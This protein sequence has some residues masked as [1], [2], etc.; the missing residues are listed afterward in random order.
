MARGANLNHSL[1][2]VLLVQRGLTVILSGHNAFYFASYLTR[3][4][5]RRL[6]ATVLAF[7]NLALGV[8]SLA[9]GVLPMV[10]LNTGTGFALSSQLVAASLS[11]AVA[12]VMAAL[13]LRQRI[14]RR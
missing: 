9:F 13:I 2:T 5:R 10:L 11:L 7:I 3:R 1:E 8:E 12:L 14:R 4:G 6:G